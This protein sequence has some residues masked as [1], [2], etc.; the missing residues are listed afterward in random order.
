MIDAAQ[1]LDE[2]VAGGIDMFHTLSS[3][4]I[5]NSYLEVTEAGRGE[6]KHAVSFTPPKRSE[7]KIIQLYRKNFNQ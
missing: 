5:P 3:I 7:V 2:S 6:K 1:E 4:V